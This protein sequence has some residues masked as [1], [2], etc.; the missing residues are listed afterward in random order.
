M[1]T[2][3][4]DR[5][6][7]RPIDSLSVLGQLLLV[8]AVVGHLI[9]GISQR[10]GNFIMG[11][12]SI[13][14]NAVLNGFQNPPALRALR[15]LPKT[16]RSALE[17]FDVEG[18]YT[19]YAVC[20]ACHCT[21]A[22]DSNSRYTKKTCTNKPLP[23]Q[24]CGHDLL[25]AAGKPLKTYLHYSFR[26]YLA[27]LFSNAALEQD[28]DDAC[29]G[30][31]KQTSSNIGAMHGPFDGEFLKTFLGHDKKLFCHR[32]GTE[33]R[34]LFS[35]CVDFFRVEGLKLRGPNTSVGIIAL[36]CLNLPP[37]VRYAP[38]NLYL[39]GIVPGP[40]E[41]LLTDLNHYLKPIVSDMVT[42]YEEGFKFSRTALHDGG[43]TVRTAIANVVCDLPASR[44]TAALAPSTSRIFCNVCD[45]WFQTRAEIKAKVPWRPK[46]GDT[47]YEDWRP[48]A[49]LREDAEK[50]RKAKTAD[51]QKDL[52]DETG[53]RYSELWRLPYWDPTRQLVVDG[54]H[55]LLEGLAQFHYVEA[56]QLTE[57]ACK[58]GDPDRPAFAHDFTE[59]DPVDESSTP[60]DGNVKSQKKRK[61]E[62]NVRLDILRIHA[63][64]VMSLD[65]EE[66][67]KDGEA[68]E[69]A[70]EDAD[71]DEDEEEESGDE[72][73][74]DKGTVK[75]KKTK[76]RKVRNT[77]ATLTAWL[78]RCRL[79]ALKFVADDLKL[80]V[81]PIDDESVGPREKRK[82]RKPNKLD[83]AVYL[84][85]WVRVVRSRLNKQS[86]TS[87]AAYQKATSL[88]YRLD[89]C[90]DVRSCC[91]T[92]VAA[93]HQNYCETVMD[94]FRRWQFWHEEG[95]DNKGGCLAHPLSHLSANY[96]GSD[97]GLWI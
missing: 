55:N 74:S 84:R 93:R 86:L 94:W 62:E 10:D 37:E 1:L 23:G 2:S 59:P 42:G 6:F 92:K 70:D 4:A 40:H 13:A 19:V 88:Y 48:R 29:D 31:K 58:G 83:Y 54:M 39:A 17:H 57:V 85:N 52:F 44:K 64:L 81:Q 89:A 76:R 20:P 43:R 46:L 72:E 77:A 60:D 16:L 63:R 3:L 12:L 21:Y 68:D 32:P 36:A 28:M 49:N 69:V 61:S 26:D 67:E 25:D 34:L 65:E 7:E 96:F 91:A 24:R 47:N 45:C 15:E 75:G 9:M 30:L 14:L 51:D 87:F 5:H 53:V 82:R 66:V 18:Q 27:G 38:E 95:W 97:V 11:V 71:E 80:D 90:S 50:W 56:L 41:P 33:G 79:G 73:V 8:L 35:L 78:F 22:P